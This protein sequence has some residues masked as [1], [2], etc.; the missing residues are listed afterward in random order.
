M[1]TNRIYGITLRHLYNL[2]HSLDRMSDVFYW[3]TVDLILWGLTGKYFL[4]ISPHNEQVLVAIIGGILFWILPWRSQNEITLN[5][6]VEI[7]D[8]NLVN[9]FIAPL[10]FTEWIFS[11]LMLGFIKAM[12]SLCFASFVAFLLYKINI[13][14]YGFY[15]IPFLFLLLMSGWWIGFIVAAIIL[16]YGSRIQTL[17]WT[18]PWIVAPFSAIYFPVSVLPNWAQVISRALPSSYVFEG[19]RQVILQHTLNWNYLT[20]SL[21]LNI[22]YLILSILFFRSSFKNAFDRGLQGIS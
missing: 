17:T 7:W 2:R 8:R 5:V 22:V 4:T 3:P 15:L 21:V 16:R 1:K 6:C 11:L 13:F 18:V 19:A 9:L 10:K 20:I 12:I 14:T